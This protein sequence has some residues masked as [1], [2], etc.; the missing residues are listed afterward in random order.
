MSARPIARPLFVLVLSSVLLIGCTQPSRQQAIERP[1]AR[2]LALLELVLPTPLLLVGEQHDAPEHQALQ[3]DLVSA[4]AERALLAALVLE[5]ATEGL[6]TAGLPRTAS[7]AQVRQ[8]LQWE[9]ASSTWPWP[10]YAPVAMRAVRAGVPVMG[11]NLPRNAMGEAMKN[12]GLDQLLSPQMLAEQQHNIQQGHCGLLPER[13]LAPMA[14]V[15]IARDQTL[16]RTASQALQPGRTVLLVAGN[17]HVRRDLGVPQHL[18]PEVNFRV[19]SAQVDAEE[20]A[21]FPPDRADQVWVSPARPP[22]DYCA[23]FREQMGR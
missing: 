16:A 19:I 7:E 3:A 4:L 8:A 12:S 23:E 6:S 13:Q 15:Q 1:D 21:V 22:H 5:M 9:A 11:G 10:V 18:A 14:R 20:T 2:V 17:Q